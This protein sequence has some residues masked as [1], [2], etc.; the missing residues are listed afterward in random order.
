METSRPKSFS[1]AP[2]GSLQPCQGRNH[3]A[4]P[5]VVRARDA[6]HTRIPAQ[7]PKDRQSPPLFRVSL[8]G[9]G[10]VLDVDKLLVEI[11][12]CKVDVGRLG[13]DGAAMIISEKDKEDEKG[14]VAGI[15]STGQGAGAALSRRI[16]GRNSE[17][18][19]LARDIPE[20]APYMCS[21]LVLQ[22]RFA[23]KGP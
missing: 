2:P 20:L 10:A 21:A 13:I 5:S 16:L 15:G 8:I 4:K 11:A 14:L 3:R 6:S 18:I 19:R 12:E 7:E 23:R 1:R 22:R 17:D 9:P